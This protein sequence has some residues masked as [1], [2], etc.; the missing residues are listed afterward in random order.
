MERGR[1]ARSRR[2][3]TAA[4]TAHFRVEEEFGCATSVEEQ[5]EATS[6][7]ENP[8]VTATPGA[9]TSLRSATPSSID[10]IDVQERI[11]ERQKTGRRR[12]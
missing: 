9:P 11:Y 8:G 12:R 5:T 7:V 4:R 10:L 2:A 1:T 6:D 3:T